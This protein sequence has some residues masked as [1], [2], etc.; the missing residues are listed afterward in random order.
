MDSGSA[1]PSPYSWWTN[2]R[3]TFSKGTANENSTHA[4]ASYVWRDDIP[5]DDGRRHV[6]TMT[7]RRNLKTILRD[8]CLPELGRRHRYIHRQAMC[9]WLAQHRVPYTPS[10]LNRYLVEWV[11]HGGIFSAGREWYSC[12]ENRASV[13][14]EPIA[15]LAACIRK[16]FPLLRFA[17]WSTAQVNP[18]LHH[19]VGQPTAVLNVEKDTLEDVA[20]HLE[21]SSWKG[22][23]NP[24]GSVAR[25][26][27][28]RLRGVILRSLHSAAPR[29]PQGFAS[30][31]QLLVELRLE[32]DKVAL[33]PETEFKAM[34]TR[35]VSE[36]RIDMACFQRYLSK[37]YL[38]PGD[39][40]DNPLASQFT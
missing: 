34:A 13:D 1:T 25:R 40:F 10:T 26:F 38:K 32:V 27:T 37:R 4:D 39:V 33:L 23:P 6:S 2:R 30:V 20:A 21:A 8:E 22:V 7:V 31:E 35:W 36:T 14:T 18:W 29:A 15:E 19:L 12:L 17:V 11:R 16:A 5:N 24:H 9:R 28:P 3:N